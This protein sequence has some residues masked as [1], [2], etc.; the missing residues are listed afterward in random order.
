M[1]HAK[2]YEGADDQNRALTSE[3]AKQAYAISEKILSASKELGFDPQ[4]ILTSGAKRAY[5]TARILAGILNR[6]EFLKIEKT[7][8][9]GGAREYMRILDTFF[10]SHDCLIIVAHNPT[11]S[12]LCT[13][14]AHSWTKIL[15]PAAALGLEFNATIGEGSGKEL[16]YFD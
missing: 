10:H 13:L 12:D 16:F 15:T 11:L 2:A 1:R 5:D 9:D 4:I 6:S 14:L 7:L 8:Y 3:G